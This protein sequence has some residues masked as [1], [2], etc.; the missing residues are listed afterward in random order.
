M[1]AQAIELVTV[2]KAED[3]KLAAEHAEELLKL[4]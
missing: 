1:E 3:E 2:A 4:R